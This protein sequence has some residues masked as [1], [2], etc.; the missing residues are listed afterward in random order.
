MNYADAMNIL[1][2]HGLT[3][4][5][6]EDHHYHYTGKLGAPDREL[7]LT[8]VPAKRLRRV[9]RAGK[10]MYDDPHRTAKR[11]LLDILA[12]LADERPVVDGPAAP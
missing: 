4:E 5:D 9:T 1:A 8:K 2:K 3:V 10:L 11:A 12:Q 6:F 7:V